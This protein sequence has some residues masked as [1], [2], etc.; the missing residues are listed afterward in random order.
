MLSAQARRTAQEA[1]ARMAV[2]EHTAEAEGWDRMWEGQRQ[3]AV[4]SSEVVEELRAFRLRWR[5]EQ[6][7]TRGL[8]SVDLRLL[9]GLS[10][11]GT[12]G[13]Q[14]RRARELARRQ[15]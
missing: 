1:Y 8:S 6:R 11:R 9:H 13:R 5:A 2:V 4:A 7:V 12:G 14:R 10:A 3:H 15:G